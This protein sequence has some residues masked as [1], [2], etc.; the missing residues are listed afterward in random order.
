MEQSITYK[1]LVDAF[2]EI[3]IERGT[4]LEVH[5][6]LS[7]FGY[8]EGGAETVISA[9]KDVVGTD[10]SIF[11]PSLRLSHE[12][13][14]TDKDKNLG[15]TVKIKILPEER[16]RSAMGIIADTFRLQHDTVTGDGIFQISGW[17]KYADKAAKGGLDFAIH[18]GGM[19]LLLGVDIYKLTAMHYVEDAIPD[20]IN[21]M[22]ANDES[23]NKTYPQDEWFV[24]TKHPSVKPWYTIQAMAYEKGLIKD[25]HIGNCK[26]M[27]FSIWDVVSL[28]KQE[29][30]NNPYK[31]YGIE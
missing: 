29:L 12:L 1:N 18:N 14:L 8:V 26:Y 20:E 11:M 9:L 17:G 21:K 31:L 27:Y 15:I 25:G 16:E 6:S 10:G 13:P 7:S 23:I 4:I 28:Y 5:S 19:A 2:R 3:G 30:E 22:F 24:E